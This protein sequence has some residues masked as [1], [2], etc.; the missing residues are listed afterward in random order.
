MLKGNKGEWSEIF[1]FL[2]VLS[3]GKLYSSDSNLQRLG[4][5]QYFPV[6][7]VI[8]NEEQEISYYTGDVIEIRDVSNTATALGMVPSRSWSGR[9]EATGGYIVATSSGD[10]VAFHIYNRDNFEDYLIENTRFETA[11][12]GRHGF[13][14]LYEEDGQTK[15]NLNLQIRFKK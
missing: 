4:D 6:I 14:L 15:I 7:R 3:E 13:G 5:D 8:R 10:V 1:V 9:D 2:S 12:T 11:S